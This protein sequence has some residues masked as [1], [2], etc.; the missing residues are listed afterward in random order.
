MWYHSTRRAHIIYESTAQLKAISDYIQK[1]KFK[2]IQYHTTS[3]D[4][5]WSIQCIIA[6]MGLFK[7]YVYKDW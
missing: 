1:Y 5:C 6:D 3:N 2:I 4:T 7:S